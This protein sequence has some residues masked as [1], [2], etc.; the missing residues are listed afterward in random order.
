MYNQK[1]RDMANYV[2]SYKL[3]KNRWKQFHKAIES[4]SHFSKSIDIWIDE[5]TMVSTKDCKAVYVPISVQS[6]WGEPNYY[7]ARFFEV[8]PTHTNTMTRYWADDIY[9]NK[10]FKAISGKLRTNVLRFVQQHYL[11]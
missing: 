8:R 11:V 6:E 10:T 2:G 4:Y 3:S 1:L 9:S 5:N 7:F